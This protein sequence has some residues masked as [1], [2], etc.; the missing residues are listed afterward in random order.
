[1]EN[2]AGTVSV[3]LCQ[4]LLLLVVTMIMFYTRPCSDPISL[5]NK[6]YIGTKTEPES[7]GARCGQEWGDRPGC[8]LALLHLWDRLGGHT[9]VR[10]F[11]WA[12]TSSSNLAF[13]SDGVVSPPWPAS[14]CG[15]AP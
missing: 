13:S 8:A 2:G 7:G 9:Q 3:L 12:G 11:P 14:A 1:M 6:D 5:P 15:W 4:C 10:A